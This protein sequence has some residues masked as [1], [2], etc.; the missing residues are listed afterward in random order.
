MYYDKELF[1]GYMYVVGLLGL[2]VFGWHMVNSP[3]YYVLG[4]MMFGGVFAGVLHAV[5]SIYRKGYEDHR[6]DMGEAA[7]KK[8]HR[9]ALRNV[10]NAKKIRQIHRLRPPYLR[11]IKGGLSNNEKYA[12]DLPDAS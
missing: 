8:W 10:G 2:F 5:N 9:D 1:W 11:E 6:A 7:N 12:G 4:Y 3:Q